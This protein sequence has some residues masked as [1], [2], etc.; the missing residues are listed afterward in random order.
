MSASRRRALTEA[1]E[2]VFALSGSAATTRL[3]V[4]ANSRTGLRC[5]C[6]KGT[7]KG[8]VTSPGVDFSGRV[9]PLGERKDTSVCSV[10]WGAGALRPRPQFDRA[11][12][13]DQAIVAGN[14]P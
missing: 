7:R 3:W 1:L 8:L 10:C 14:R 4:D 12:M 2:A 13:D 9:D 5:P 6:C 11:R